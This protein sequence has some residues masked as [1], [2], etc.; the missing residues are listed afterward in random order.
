VSSSQNTC[1]FSEAHLKFFEFTHCN[2]SI[3]EC[4]LHTIPVLFQRLIRNF[5]NFHIAM[6]AF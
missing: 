2:G 1:T 5:L 3:L 6:A 4:H